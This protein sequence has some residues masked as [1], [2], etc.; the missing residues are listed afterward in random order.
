MLYSFEKYHAYLE[1]KEFCLRTDN[2]ALTWLL[3]HTEELGRIRCWVL[4]LV[5]FKFKV[6]H[7][8]GKTN[9]ANC[10]IRRYEDLSVEALFSVCW[11][12]S[13]H[14]RLFSQSEN[15]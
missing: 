10:L 3:R 13:T 15:V 5:L 14:L 9:V 6:C 4:H 11:S 7:I 1:H 8:S 2:Q 12:F